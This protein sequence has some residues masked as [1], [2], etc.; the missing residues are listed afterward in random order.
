M[1]VIIIEDEVLAQEK[2]EAMLKCIDP[3]I[4]VIAKLGSVKESKHYLAQSPPADLAFVD[5]QL[6]DD[7]SF[8]IFRS[9]PLQF[10]VIFTTAYDQYLLESFEHNAIDYLL[11][12]VTEEKL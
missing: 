4:E 8:E 2:L 5:I 1:K 11:K 7:H 10:P 6:S 12:P 3:S 9:F